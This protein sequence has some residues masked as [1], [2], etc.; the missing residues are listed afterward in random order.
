MTTYCFECGRDFENER[1]TARF[2]SPA[3]RVAFN[4]RR[5]NQIAKAHAK[6]HKGEDFTAY[7]VDCEAVGRYIWYNGRLFLAVG[8]AG[9]PDTLLR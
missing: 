9:R 7:N 2:C 3:C 8:E 1:S 4:R 5:P 6:L